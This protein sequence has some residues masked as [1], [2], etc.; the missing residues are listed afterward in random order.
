MQRL[1]GLEGLTRMNTRRNTEIKTKKLN[2]NLQNQNPS[3]K[4]DFKINSNIKL[5]LK[6]NNND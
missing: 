4:L 1:T 5:N 3:P 6:K 2:F